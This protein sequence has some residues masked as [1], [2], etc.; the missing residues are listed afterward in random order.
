M[1]AESFRRKDK[2]WKEGGVGSSQG[3]EGRGKDEARGGVGGG[4]LLND[5]FS[6]KHHSSQKKRLEEGRIFTHL[7]GWCRCH[8]SPRRLQRKAQ[9]NTD[10]SLGVLIRPMKGNNRCEHLLFNG[11]RSSINQQAR[12]TRGR[13]FTSVLLFDSRGAFLK[14]RTSENNKTNARSGRR[15]QN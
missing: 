13:P 6:V 11:N 8:S 10:M 3:E 4:G 2:K 9:P 15:M 1:L 14:S 5:R 12:S 7:L